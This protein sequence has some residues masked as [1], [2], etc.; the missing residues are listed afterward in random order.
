MTQ[1]RT[2]ALLAFC[3][4][5]AACAPK[6]TLENPE[7]PDPL[8]L[9]DPLARTSAAQIKAD[10]LRSLADQ[11]PGQTNY[12]SRRLYQQTFTLAGDV[13]QLLEGPS[14]SGSFD[15]QIAVIR[16]SQASV[17]NTTDL[18]PRVD[19]AARGILAALKTIHRE[20]FQ[21]DPAYVP[22]L[23]KLQDQLNKLDAVRGPLHGVVTAEAIRNAADILQAMAKANIQ[24]L[25]T[26]SAPAK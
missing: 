20:Q 6:P 13:L 2:W 22:N 8:P 19:E 5:L 18:D 24:Q 7:T 16:Q 23:N 14:P 3:G 26:N 9:A 1:L 17:L 12:D 21:L 25:G 4:W 10:Q 15:S 11:L